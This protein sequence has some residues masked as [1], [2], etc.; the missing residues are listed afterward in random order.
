MKFTAAEQRL[1]ARLKKQERNW[2][3]TRWIL[4]V[5]GVIMGGLWIWLILWIFDTTEGRPEERQM[6]TALAYPKA[7][8]GLTAAVLFFVWALRD[9]YGS[10]TRRLLLRLIE[11]QTASGSEQAAAPNSRPPSQLASSSE[12]QSSDSQRTPSSGGCG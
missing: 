4:L 2:R 11:G 12:V 8:F 10:P 7:L 1:I 9:W 5:G 3:F 6:I